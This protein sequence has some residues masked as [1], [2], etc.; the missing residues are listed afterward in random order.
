[1]SFDNHRCGQELPEVLRLWV[2]RQTHELSRL[3]W[4]QEMDPLVGC[5]RMVMVEAI[6][7]WAKTVAC[8]EG[9]RHLISAS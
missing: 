1:M 6:M 8:E 3:E 9:S 2:V 7:W 4:C 5:H